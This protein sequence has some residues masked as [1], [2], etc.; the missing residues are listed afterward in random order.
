MAALKQGIN[1]FSGEKGLGAALTNPTLLAK[2]K[3]GIQG[4]YP[5]SAYGKDF[6]DVEAAYKTLKDKSGTESARRYNDDLMHKL[7]SQKL[8]R[9]PR[10]IQ[11]I[12]AH[13]GVPWL[14]SCSHYTYAKSASF[15][16]WEGLGRESRF[17][18]ALIS[19][20]EFVK[21]HPDGEALL[22]LEPAQKDLF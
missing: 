21:S 4:D 2:S 7:I 22:G 15:I 19:A 5:A 3:G 9:F 14:E 1:I 17:I 11:S 20:Y 6:P 16:S 12:D 8:Y 18:R 13:G 10:L